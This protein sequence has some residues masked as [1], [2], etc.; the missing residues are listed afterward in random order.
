MS[1]R[2]LSFSTANGDT[3]AYVVTPENDR[4]KAVIVIQEWWGLNTHIKD[5]A[6]RYAAEGFIG[7]A[8]DLTTMFRT[9]GLKTDPTREE[10]SAAIR[11]VTPEIANRAIDAVAKYGMS[12]PAALPKYGIIGFCWGGARSFHHATHAPTLGAS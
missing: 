3:T 7:I 6:N 8:P 9:S 10:G 11:Q 2:T 5:I 12:L 4:K 1:E